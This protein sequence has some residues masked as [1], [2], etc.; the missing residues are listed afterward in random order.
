MANEAEKRGYDKDPE[1]VRVMKQQM[2][3][4]FLQKDF[5]SKL[6]VEDVP[7]AQVE[8][9]YKEHPAEFNQKD[10]VRVGEIVTKDKGKADKAYAEAKALPKAAAAVGDQKGFKDVV[11][12]YSEDEDGKTRA[13]DLGFMDKEST[14]QPKAVVEAAFKLAE[15]GDVAAPIKTD[16]GWVGDSPDAE[17]PR[18][19]PPADRGQAPDPAAPV[20]RHADQGDGRLRRRPE[21]E[22]HDRDQ[23]REPVQGRHRHRQQGGPPGAG[24]IAAPGMSSPMGAPGAVPGT[25]GGAAARDAGAAP[26][27]AR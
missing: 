9:Y 4:K 26:G 8:K 11:T 27:T 15:V 2:I 6:K 19:Q 5:E 3:S 10:E 7:D 16:K 17:A 1:V 13:G 20:P 21:E 23:G 22:E 12:K 25:P 24:R 18:V 14:R